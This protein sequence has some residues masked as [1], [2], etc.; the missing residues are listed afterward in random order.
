M[1][2]SD[3]LTTVQLDHALNVAERLTQLRDWQHTWEQERTALDRQLRL[4]DPNSQL[5]IQRGLQLTRLQQR[6]RMKLVHA[7]LEI[8]P[9]VIN[10]TGYDTLRHDLVRQFTQLSQEERLLWLQNFLFIM[11][12]ELRQL[13]DKIAQVRAFR[14]LGQRRN[15]LLGG[16]SGMGK[17]TY[18]DWYTANYLPTMLPDRNHVPVIKIDAPVSN[19]TPK[20]LF[21]RIILECGLSYFRS[22]NEEDL[23]MRLA[24]YFHTCGTELLI[25]DEV[26]HIKRPTIKRRLLEV[27]NLAPSLP[28]LCASCHPT[29]WV[30]G[31]AEV[32]GRWNDYFELRQYTGER[33]RQL[34][35]YL[36]LLLPFPEPSSLA[37]YS[38]GKDKRNHTP[39]PAQLIEQWTGGILRDIMI[40]V[41]D[42]SIRAIQQRLPKLTPLLLEATWKDIQTY[43]VTDFLDVLQRRKGAE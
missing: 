11:T 28:I 32:A 38:V 42:A 34:L 9:D 23:L 36:E 12:P 19:K 14:T 18:L 25:V 26:E 13:N 16:P 24:L 7:P 5:D 41:M 29:T 27:S 22:D 21:Q 1:T 4:L 30:Q 2:V 3:H 6:L 31:D 17:T 35:A 40:L 8:A 10:R 43:Q 15:F 33:L 37:V 20:P 39:G